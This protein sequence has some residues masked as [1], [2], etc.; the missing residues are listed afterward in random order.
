MTL[1]PFDVQLIQDTGI[2][3]VLV[4]QSV[5]GDNQ[6][7]IYVTAAQNVNGIQLWSAAISSYMSTGGT[8]VED[9]LEDSTSVIY[10]S[11]ESGPGNSP[12]VSLELKGI[13]VPPGR[14]LQL[15]TGA[16]GGTHKVSATV[17]YTLL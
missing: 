6:T 8:P 10:L 5:E 17:I 12:V 9:V 16:S 15:T 1:V 4:A 13:L 7:D 2:P 11:L 14:A 3:G